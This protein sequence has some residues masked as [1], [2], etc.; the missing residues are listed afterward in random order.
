[1]GFRKILPKEISGN[2]FELIGDKW[3]L[4]TAGNSEGF[5][6][7]TASWGGLGVLWGKPVSFAFIRPA[8][9]TFGFMEKGD[10][11]TLSFYG[12]EY[13]KQLNL[14]GT[15][16]GRDT[17]KV[18]ETGFT[19][20]FSDEGAPYFA[21]AELVLVCRKMYA[22]DINPEMF[23]DKSIEKWYNDDYHRV[24]VGEITEVLENERD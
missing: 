10:Y 12:E 1:M 15:K 3:M 18:A 9:H 19:P 22:D 5:N 6:M 2:T 13:R 24:Y 14:C 7:M 17:D 8:R 20:T 11:Y 4:I 16:S 23:A 21:E